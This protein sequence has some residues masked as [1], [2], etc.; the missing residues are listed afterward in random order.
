MD[1]TGTLTYGALQVKDIH[2][3]DKNIYYVN[4]VS[5]I[6]STEKFSEHPL[7]KAVLDYSQSKGVIAKDP[8]TFEIQTGKGV[9]AMPR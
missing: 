2:M 8:E 1:K 3:I 7:G 4:F 5:L 9:I 6:A